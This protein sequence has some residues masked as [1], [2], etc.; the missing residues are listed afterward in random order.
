[1]SRLPDFLISDEHIVKICIICEG[2]EEYDYLDRI[3]SLN[4][5]NKIY[6]VDLENADGNGNIPARYQDKFQNGSYDVVFV[7]C[8]TDKKPYEQYVDI[9]NKINEFHGV[10]TAA[11]AVVIFGN[12]C[13]MQIVIEHWTDVKLSSPAK[14]MNAA[15]IK[16][17]TGVE[18]Y[19]GRADQRAAMME[20]ITF[21]N[22]YAMKERLSKF[23]TND[24][25]LNSSNFVKFTGMLEEEDS[26]WI[27]EIQTALE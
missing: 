3:R 19:K 15:I 21:E 22:Y 18:H 2:P 24:E 16:E 26:E 8:D 20:Q 23:E 25:V 9:K 7:F 6:D 27:Q 1:M 17:C 5:W 14:K 4:V 13:T 10:D 12:P 11:D